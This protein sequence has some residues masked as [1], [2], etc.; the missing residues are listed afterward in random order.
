MGRI[1]AWFIW[2]FPTWPTIRLCTEPCW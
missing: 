2:I 1:P